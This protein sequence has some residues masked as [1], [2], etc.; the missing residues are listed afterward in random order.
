MD[1]KPSGI[2]YNPENGNEET[3][4]PLFER[5][6][7]SRD[8][9]RLA[10][11]FSIAAFAGYD[12]EYEDIFYPQPVLFMSWQILAAVFFLVGCTS[13]RRK[14]RYVFLTPCLLGGA[15]YLFSHGRVIQRILE[16]KRSAGIILFWLGYRPDPLGTVTFKDQILAIVILK[17][18]ATFPA[19]VVTGSAL[20]GYTVAV[21]IYRCLG[22]N[23]RL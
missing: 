12:Y 10:V 22:R 17:E 20:C 23:Q 9:F 21:L 3:R 18:V 7:R 4:I 13:F 5:N 6:Y 16:H 8:R 1:R 11:I 14:E 2:P 19:L 15:F